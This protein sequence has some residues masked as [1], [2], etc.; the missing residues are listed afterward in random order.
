M[1][2]YEDRKQKIFFYVIIIVFNLWT[3]EC[4]YLYYIF[5][6]IKCVPNNKLKICN[7]I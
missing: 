3:I 4:I 5:T 6:L 2:F 1:Q 7:V